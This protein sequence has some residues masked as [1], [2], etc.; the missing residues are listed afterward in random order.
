M[1]NL[2][3]QT[4]NRGELNLA[5]CISYLTRVC[6]SSSPALPTLKDLYIH[7]GGLDLM[8]VDWQHYIKNHQWLRLLRP[9]TYVKNLYVSKE[10]V[11]SIVP[12]L[13][14]LIGDRTTEVL[15]VLQNIFYEGSCPGRYRALRCCETAHQAPGNCFL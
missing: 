12:A 13:Q 11:P 15:P 2:S 1:A 10:F 9:F 8:C 5:A 14:E 3:S 4:S 7:E 6:T